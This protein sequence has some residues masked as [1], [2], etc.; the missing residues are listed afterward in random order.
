MITPYYEYNKK[1]ET[2]YLKKDGFEYERNI[3][4]GSAHFNY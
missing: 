4:V 2:N 1:N 3:S